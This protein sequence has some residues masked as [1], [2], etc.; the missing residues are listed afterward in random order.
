MTNSITLSVL[1]GK[2]VTLSNNFAHNVYLSKE[3][4]N[5]ITLLN[6]KEK[7][8]NFNQADECFKLKNILGRASRLLFGRDAI[9]PKVKL[10]IEF[11]ERHW[12]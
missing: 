11:Q 3:I 6:L 8:K 2:E 10:C 7:A 9:K 4:D 5:V 1:G 12:S